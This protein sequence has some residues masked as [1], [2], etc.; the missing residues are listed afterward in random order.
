ME[1]I[2]EIIKSLNDF[3]YP[4]NRINNTT[5]EIITPLSEGDHK[6]FL[7]FE[8]T[9][10]IIR[11]ELKHLFGSIDLNKSIGV[12]EF[13]QMLV[14]NTNGTYKKTSK[15]I[16]VK[17]IENTPYVF[18]LGYNYFNLKWDSNEIADIISLQLS[19]LKFAFTFECS[20][21]DYIY[22]FQH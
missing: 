18:L 15:Y 2:D 14:D 13:L 11:I 4:S 17:I 1:K 5:Y 16:G 9:E 10:D 3:N 20:I 21:P 12:E 7:K 8:I 19:E 22:I 6:T